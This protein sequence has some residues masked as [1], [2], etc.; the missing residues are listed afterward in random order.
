MISV[1]GSLAMPI[2]VTAHPVRSLARVIPS[3][4]SPLISGGVLGIHRQNPP[5]VDAILI[6][7]RLFLNGH[8]SEAQFRGGGG[9]ERT[10]IMVRSTPAEFEQVGSH[11]LPSLGFRLE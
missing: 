3:T 4:V 1:N 6:V 7:G 2:A 9:R 10:Q 8:E 11:W 5:K